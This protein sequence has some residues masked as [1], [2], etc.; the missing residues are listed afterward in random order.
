[1]TELNLKISYRSK[2]YDLQIKED[3][4]VKELKEEIQKLINVPP[5]LQKI[6]G[7]VK[8]NE[9]EKT[10]KEIKLLNKTKLTVVGS[11]L[12]DVL[13]ASA[14][15]SQR[16]TSKPEPKIEKVEVN[17]QKEH[18]KIL[19]KG[20]PKDAEKGDKNKQLP[21]PKSIKGLYNKLGENIRL[22]FKND[23]LWISSNE[24]TE[25]YSYL[26]IRDVDGEPIIG[27]EDYYIMYLQLGLHEKIWIYY[28]PAQYFKG[29]KYSLLG[30]IYLKKNNLI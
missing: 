12:D 6:L 29:I 23:E 28:V 18:E 5:T 10:L 17:S 3:A 19:K 4:K 2:V 9:N 21:A 15:S 7:K 16:K 1:M 24:K 11:T 13:D 20:T 27:N 22:T 30:L 26:Q 8:L 14:P 25:K